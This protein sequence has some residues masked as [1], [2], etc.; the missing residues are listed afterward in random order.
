MAKAS[1]AIIA[2][3]AGEWSPLMQTRADLQGYSAAAHTLQNWLPTIQGPIIRRAGTGFIRQVK[4]GTDRTWMMPFVK[5]RNDAVMI[6]YGDLYCRFYSNRAPILTGSGGAITGATQASPVVITSTAHGYSDGQDVYLSGIGGMG[7]LNFRWFKVSSA[8]ANTFELQTIHGDGVDGTGYT[9]YT[10]GG[11]VDIPYEIV[12]PYS[13]AALVSENGEFNLD[14]VQDGDA[15]YITDRAGVLAPRVLERTGATAWAFSTFAPNDGPW[16]DINSTADKIYSSAA[17]GT[18]TLTS[19]SSIFTAG[20]VGALIR[21]D[22]EELTATNQWQSGNPYSA[23]DYVR[24]DGKE[25]QANTTGTAGTT[26]PS[27]ASGAAKDGAGGVEWGFRTAGYG[28]ARITAQAGTTATAD[29]LT[30][31]PQTVV[32]SGNATAFW[33]RGAWSDA[34]GYPGVVSFYLERL[35]FGNG[36]RLDMSVSGSEDFAIDSVGETLPESAVSVNMPGSQLNE[37]VGLTEGPVLIV[38]TEGV[39]FIVDKQSVADAFGP[40]NVKVV[41][42]TTYGS[43]PVKPVKIGDTVAFVQGSGRKVRALQ[44]SFDVDRFVAPDLLVRSEHLGFPTIT[45]MCRQEEPYQMVWLWRSDG[46]LLSF[47]FDTTQEAKAWARH[48]ISGTDAV[49]ETAQVIPAPDGE[50][51]DV[52]LIVSRTINGAQRRY[53]EYLQPE[54]LTGDDQS[55]ARYGDSGLHYSGA[56]STVLY[57]FDHMEGE[58]VGVLADGGAHP[59]KTVTAGTVTLDLSTTTAYCGLAYASV[60]ASLPINSGA[61]DG[62]SLAKTKRITDCAFRLINSRGGEIGHD[63]TDF[64]LVPDSNYRAPSTPM[65]TPSPLY[66]GDAVASWPGGYETDAKIWYRNQSMFPDTL[67]AVLPQVTTQESR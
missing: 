14:F 4:D 42:Q 64:E 15:I 53:V 10:S 60:Y 37:I 47:T 35:A 20:D 8:A 2:L 16:L 26:I 41:S 45:G 1:P 40:N 3:N 51:D 30:R 43:R 52:W 62:T 11:T 13:A 56:A 57:G 55:D 23:G 17:T 9:A 67:A 49:V 6:E 46:V 39:E 21:L 31:F 7:E 25:Y 59:A 58:S 19:G 32:G 29:V 22:Q 65:D 66:S 5:S 61:A 36:T 18:V 12:S 63:G 27:H 34:N 38:S 54:H 48:G 24:S 33:R 50:R 28:I 44:F